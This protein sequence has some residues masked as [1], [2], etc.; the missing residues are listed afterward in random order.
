M[1][2]KNVVISGNNSTYSRRIE[3]FSKRKIMLLFLLFSFCQIIVLFSYVFGPEVVEGRSYPI[4]MEGESSKIRK[5]SISVDNFTFL[6]RFVLVSLILMRKNVSTAE[7]G[8]LSVSFYIRTHNGPVFEEQIASNQKKL[9]F[10]FDK[11]VSLSNVFNLY[12]TNLVS[13]QKIEIQSYFKVLDNSKLSGSFLLQS[14]NSNTSLLQLFYRA[15]FFIVFLSFSINGLPN[16]KGELHLLDYFTYALSILMTIAYNPLFF[17]SYFAFY[18]FIEVI[19]IISG[20]LSI[21]VLLM[22][23]YLIT[24]L[25]LPIHGIEILK[26]ISFPF[27]LC[28]TMGTLINLLSFII[29]HNSDLHYLLVRLSIA[30]LFAFV[31]LFVYKYES[32]IKLEKQLL[33]TYLLLSFSLYYFFSYCFSKNGS[34]SSYRLME[35]SQLV[36][37]SI[38]SVFITYLY[39][40]IDLD[41][42]DPN[43]ELSE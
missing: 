40:P 14:G 43:N 15:V 5:I 6:N 31:M 13:F 3:N 28:G 30:F 20:Y 35:T 37:I 36:P 41:Q 11:G 32:E 8:N 22:T 16:I 2:L 23:I 19:N 29:V 27:I 9:S 25:N 42:I 7:K 17:V 33:L 24:T 34:S 18:G 21:C 4:E 39:K 12:S 10:F 38:L 26:G 1:E